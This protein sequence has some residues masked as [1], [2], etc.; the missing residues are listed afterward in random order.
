M[1]DQEPPHALAHQVAA[2]DGH[3]KGN[4]RDHLILIRGAK[5]MD[6]S[7]TEGG[8]LCAPGLQLPRI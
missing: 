8:P 7:S 5:V 6:R 3:K 4:S 1:L 2:L